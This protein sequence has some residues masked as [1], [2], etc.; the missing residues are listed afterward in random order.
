MQ[1]LQKSQYILQ[2]NY[3]RYEKNI[4]IQ[5]IFCKKIC[6]FE[7]QHCFI[8]SIFFFLILKNTIEILKFNFSTMC[9]IWKKRKNSKLFVSVRSTN[10]V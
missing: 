9:E 3:T 6:K 8:R 1:K 10:F 5:N 7:S 4:S 2:L